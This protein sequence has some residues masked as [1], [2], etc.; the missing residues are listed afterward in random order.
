[1]VMKKCP[2]CGV[3]GGSLATVRPDGR[4]VMQCPECGLGWVADFEPLGQLHEDRHYFVATDDQTLSYGYAD[5]EIVDALDVLWRAACVE[6]LQPRRGRIFDVG[7]AYGGFLDV[8]RH[9]GWDVSGIDISVSAGRVAEARGVTIRVGDFLEANIADT[10]DVVTAWEVLEHVS[11]PAGFATKVANLL[12]PGGIAIFYVPDAGEYLSMRDSSWAGFQTSLEHAMYFGKESLG[13][14]LERAGFSV[15]FAESVGNAPHKSLIAWARRESMSCSE[16]EILQRMLVGDASVVRPEHTNYAALLAAKFARSG[17]VREPLVEKDIPGLVPTPLIAANIDFY[18]DRIDRGLLTL[19]GAS[20][21]SRWEGF[22]RRVLVALMTEERKAAKELLVGVERGREELMSELKRMEKEI[23]DGRQQLDLVQSELE[24]SRNRAMDVEREIVQIKGS[25]TFLL[26]APMMARVR[27]LLPSQIRVRLFP[28]LRKVARVLKTEGIHGLRWRLAARLPGPLRALRRPL[29]S[30]IP[31]RVPEIPRRVFVELDRLDDQVPLVSIVIPC[32]NYGQYLLDAVESV[33]QQTLSNLEIIV[34]DDGSTDP[35]TTSLLDKLAGEPGDLRIIRQAN[36]GLPSAR[37]AGIR[38]ASGCYICCLDADD[39]LS[40]TYLEKAVAVLEEHQDIDL[41]YSW[42]QLFG[43]EQYIWRTE[44]FDAVRLRDYNFIPVAAVFRRTAWVKVGGYDES[45]R[46]GYEDW[47]FWLKLAAEGSQGYLI[48]EAL[49]GHRRHGRTMTHSARSQHDQLASLIRSRYPSSALQERGLRTTR[50]EV[51]PSDAFRRLKGLADKAGLRVLVLVP[52]LMVGGAESVLLQ[53]VEAAH[54]TTKWDVF[55]V[56]TLEASNE[57]IPKFGEVCHYIYSLPIFLEN[58]A[59]GEFLL[60]MI[61]RHDI[62]AVII[63]HCQAGYA[64]LPRF[65]QEFPGLFVADIL[66]ND[67]PEGYCASAEVQDRWIDLHIIVHDGIRQHLVGNGVDRQKIRLISN[68]VPTE[69]LYP[70]DEVGRAWLQRNGFDAQKRH[71]AFVG[72]LSSEK[73]P[74]LFIRLAAT[75][76]RSDVEWI[77]V[78][79]GSE[80]GRLMNLAQQLGSPCR[81]L[82]LREDVPDILR[83]IDLLVLTSEGE[84]LPMVVL[85]ALLS[86]VPIVASSVGALPE[87]IDAGRT[88]VLTTAGDI[89]AFSRVMADILDGDT[90]LDSMKA[91]CRDA[92][93]SNKQR[94]SGRLM[95]A[96]Y[97][98][99]VEEGCRCLQRH[100]PQARDQ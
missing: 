38:Q 27:L 39:V 9:L 17:R 58:Y 42:V 50:V 49:F 44:P 99:A 5:Y 32:Y 37:N 80:Q 46:Q 12:A 70:D 41:S 52:W 91:A 64:L 10:F 53:I 56:T 76:R 55:I 36:Q 79:D 29:A 86:G 21:P 93:P 30:R 33:R 98:S 26:V 35:A 88:G 77:V 62:D 95:G 25:L 16:D 43:D 65:K 18:V 22:A 23:E 15:T 31:S 63:S 4:E 96:A 14:I 89:E 75:L 84:G 81:F 45:M 69:G 90:V 100:A 73:N 7:A 94:F 59:F 74:E 71:V 2:A 66:H 83:A 1:M 13:K 20:L 51:K 72:R 6:V 82:G 78:G 8:V 11:D 87:V 34:V 57:A 67:L 24:Q 40:P 28:V 92:L 48:K 85:E 68:G 61:K 3:S 47:D 97:I 60:S 19:A 54:E